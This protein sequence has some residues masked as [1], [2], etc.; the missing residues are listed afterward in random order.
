MNQTFPM[1]PSRP[2]EREGAARP[3][4]AHTVQQCRPA[5]TSADLAFT[6]S[7]IVV[8]LRQVDPLALASA[9]CGLTA[10]IPIVSQLAGI[11]LG[12]AGLVR[13]GRPRRRGLARRGVGWGVAGLGSSGAALAVWALL[14]AAFIA[15]AAPF[16]NVGDALSR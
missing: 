2:A 15:A 3:A 12:A 1:V 10:F 13:I 5:P 11:A 9:V 4:P 7:P 16:R 6:P 8:Y 14:A